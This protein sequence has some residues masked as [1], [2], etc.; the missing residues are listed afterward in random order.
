[1]TKF[2]IVEKDNCS[3]TTWCRHIHSSFNSAINCICNPPDGRYTP[4]IPVE[5]NTRH[6]HTEHYWFE[7]FNILEVELTQVIGD[8]K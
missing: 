5:S 4:Y 2:I 6:K 8:Y 7:F 1:M 3:K